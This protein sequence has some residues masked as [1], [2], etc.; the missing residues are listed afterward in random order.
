MSVGGGEIQTPLAIV[1]K[2]PVTP[3]IVTSAATAWCSPSGSSI[4]LLVDDGPVAA[5]S[6]SGQM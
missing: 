2:P 4:Q 6:P 3:P 5:N 1:S